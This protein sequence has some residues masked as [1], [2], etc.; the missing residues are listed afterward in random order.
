VCTRSRG[1]TYELTRSRKPPKAAVAIRVQRRVRRPLL[2]PSQHALKLGDTLRE[3]SIH[4]AHQH[5][6]EKTT[7]RGYCILRDT[8]WYGREFAVSESVANASSKVERVASTVSE[9]SVDLALVRRIEVL[10]KNG[11]Q[12]TLTVKAAKICERTVAL[13]IGQERVRCLQASA[14]APHKVLE[15]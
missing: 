4:D 7:H 2:L 9:V 15:R 11:K 10:P 12:L 8:Q 1:L 6:A 5:T 13:C 14:D 3:L